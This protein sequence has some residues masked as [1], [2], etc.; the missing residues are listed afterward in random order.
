MQLTGPWQGLAQGNV[1]GHLH[2]ASWEGLEETGLCSAA[3]SAAAWDINT[4]KETSYDWTL[5]VHSFG[6]ETLAAEPS[7]PIGESKFKLC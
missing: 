2:A 3:P 5:A 4:G 6:N 1:P 7:K